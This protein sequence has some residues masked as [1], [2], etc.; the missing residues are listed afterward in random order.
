MA[1]NSFD[2]PPLANAAAQ[3]TLRMQNSL[4]RREE[5]ICNNQWRIARGKRLLRRIRALEDDLRSR[6]LK[7]IGDGEATALAPKPLPSAVSPPAADRRR[8]SARQVLPATP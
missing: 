3:I 2:Q 6:S 8:G 5:A 7:K 1:H 4:M